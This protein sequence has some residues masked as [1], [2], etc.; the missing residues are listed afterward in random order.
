MA[1]NDLPVIRTFDELPHYVQNKFQE[2][3]Y[4]YRFDLKPVITGFYNE[5]TGEEKYRVC[6]KY[7]D[8]TYPD[9]VAHYFVPNHNYNSSGLSRSISIREGDQRLTAA[10][11]K[12]F[13]YLNSA[14]RSYITDVLNKVQEVT[15]WVD[16]DPAPYSNYPRYIRNSNEFPFQQTQANETN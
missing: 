13:G 14:R 8:V 16:E 1:Y 15:Y 10:E 3:F 7:C 2:Q 9:Y 4:A 11:E 6:E 5:D 12:C